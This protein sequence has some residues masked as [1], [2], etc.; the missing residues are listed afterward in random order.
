MKSLPAFLQK[1]EWIAIAVLAVCLIV[2][3]VQLVQLKSSVASGMPISPA[4]VAE[5]VEGDL[6]G[7][8]EGRYE[9][10]IQDVRYNVREDAYQVSYEWGNP[11]ESQGW[12]TSHTLTGDGFG[13]YLGRLQN[14]QFLKPLGRDLD[15]LI[16]MQSASS[17]KG[18]S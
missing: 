8:S 5:R 3:N 10:E 6:I 15:V 9:I 7:L 18:E 11:E 12:Q 1:P 17:F 4:L 16:S 14:T 13:G 2:T